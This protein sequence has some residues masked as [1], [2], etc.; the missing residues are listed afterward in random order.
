M[1]RQK[2]FQ[3]YENCILMILTI[4]V[5]MI[6]VSLCF[7]FYYDLNDDVMMKDIMAGVY[8]GT[9]DGHNMQTLY[10]LGA[11]ISLCYRL[12]RDIPWYGLFLFLCQAGSLYLTGV[13]LLRFCRSRLA[14]AGCLLFVSVFLWGILLSH[15]TAIQ[16][17]ITCAVLAAAAVFL[18][19]TTERGLTPRQF[20]VRNLPAIVLVILAYQLRTEM[21]LLGFPLICLA[22]L[23]RWAEEKTFFQK[24]NYIRY[25]V[26]LGAILSGML[27]SRLIDFAAYGS[28][29][30][31]NFLDFFEY[32]T[33]VYDF[34]YDILTSGEHAQP[35][36][37]IGV[38]D[39]QQ[40]LLANYNFG[41][42]EAIDTEMMGK[43]AGYAGGV[44]SDSQGNGARQ[45]IKEVY[46]SARLSVSLMLHEKETPYPKIVLCGYLCVLIGGSA[47]AISTGRR[48]KK[49][50]AGE[51]GAERSVIRRWAFLWETALLVSVRTALW[52]FLL[53]RGRTP[54]RITDSV[55][56]IEFMVLAGML[57]WQ[58]ERLAAP[59]RPGCAILPGIVCLLCLPHSIAASLAD[60]RVREEANSG[61]LAIAQYCSARPDNFYF[62][63]VYSTVGFSQKMF[64]DV[65]NSL[66]NYDIMGGWM[67][68]SPLYREKLSRFGM[69]TMGEGLFLESSVYFIMET[70]TQDGGTDWMQAYYEDRGIPVTIEQTDS[71]DGRYG[72]YQVRRQKGRI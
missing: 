57:F 18:F 4:A 71:I 48:M 65:D 6:L 30:W 33:E 59:W 44:P 14:K 46:R 3:K 28:E 38:S 20:I 29:E 36:S 24:E 64:E 42:D 55:Y 13:R 67:C 70:G 41:L 27:I 22:G 54:V 9:P 60:A 72:V 62:E 12:C 52:V 17:T 2:F 8:T 1:E 51:N 15:M 45:F 16:Y 61:A 43:I 49:S 63:D 25:G 50:G 53:M 58:T 39:V 32:R 10:L 37:A 19:L 66:S 7:D 69:E 21:L 26:V 11:S 40:E 31:K 23:F 47:S 68:K 56:L 5:N 35:L 34:H